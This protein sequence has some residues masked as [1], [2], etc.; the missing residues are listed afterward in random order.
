[1]RNLSQCPICNAE[2]LAVLYTGYTHRNLADSS[3]WPVVQCGDCTHGFMSPQPEWNDLASYYSASY[4]AYDTDHG[5]NSV[6]DAITVESARQQGEFRHLALPISGKSLLDVG[7]GGGYFLRIARQLGAVVQGVEPS[8]AGSRQ[9]S[10]QDIPVFHGML[11][12]F[13]ASVSGRQFDIIT[14]NHVLEHAPDPIVTLRQMKSLLAPGGFIW[15]S[16]PNADC[17]FSRKLG[18][19]WHSADLPYHLHQFSTASLMLAGKSAG[20]SVRKSY[21]YSL[22]AA[23]AA[24]IRHYLRRSFFVPQRLTE[25]LDCLNQSFALWCAQYLDK[26]G[27]GEAIVIEFEAGQMPSCQASK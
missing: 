17:F 24:S 19:H 6:S 1:M 9:T 20:L 25:R 12:D 14:A 22:P 10:R 15:I 23:T 8:T 4:E 2:K 11:D 16:V 27:A 13:V 21:T 7:C 26:R 5:N 3:L 18:K